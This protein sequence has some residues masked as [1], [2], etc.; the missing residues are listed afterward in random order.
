MR[1]SVYRDREIERGRACVYRD[2]QGMCL[3]NEIEGVC[4]EC[5]QRNRECVFERFIQLGKHVKIAIN[6]SIT[7]AFG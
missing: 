5:V 1:G 7:G 3:E 6:I 2:R 4:T